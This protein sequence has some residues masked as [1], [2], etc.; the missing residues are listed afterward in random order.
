MEFLTAVSRAVLAPPPRLMFATARSPG[1]WSAVTQ[2]TPLMTPEMVPEPVQP[3]T[4]T[5]TSL[6][7]LATPYLLP[8]I[9]PAT[10][11]PWPL[12]SL[13][14]PLRATASM[15]L[16]ARFGLSPSKSVCV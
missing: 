5:E 9:V 4:R 13:A 15:P 10:W 11:V 16:M 2:S 3:S 12:Q 1:S 14:D 7:P 6:A 8:P